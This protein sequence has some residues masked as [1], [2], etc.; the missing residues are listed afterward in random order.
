MAGLRKRDGSPLIKPH[1]ERRRAPKREAAIRVE[2]GTPET[3]IEEN[4]GRAS[5][6][7]ALR[8]RSDLRVRPVH[9][10]STVS[11]RFEHM[12]RFVDR[13]FVQVNAEQPRPRSAGEE[14]CR[15]MPAV[16]DSRVHQDRTG[17]REVPDNLVLQHRNVPAGIALRSAVSGSRLRS[18]RR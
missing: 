11:V 17:P 10:P 8:D 18:T 5:E 9:E 4:T 16:A 6:A 2:D 13:F 15:G 7:R 1:V 12:I 14:E 3:E